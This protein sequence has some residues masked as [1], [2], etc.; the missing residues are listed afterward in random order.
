[1]GV[2]VDAP[3]QLVEALAD[4]GEGRIALV[5]GGEGST[6]FAPTSLAARVQGPLAVRRL[7]A[8]LH[9]AE[10]LAAA[11]VLQATLPDGDSVITRAGER[12]GQGWVRVSRQGAAKQGALLREREIQ[13]L[14]AAIEELQAREAELDESLGSLRE[15]MLAAE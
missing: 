10:D 9:A 8:R 11:R 5:A 3:E 13:S 4:L 2:L 1:E 7:L 14:R 6:D 15:R 12:L